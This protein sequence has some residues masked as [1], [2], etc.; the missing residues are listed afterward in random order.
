MLDER[1]I[2]PKAIK[3]YLL[4]NF[5]YTKDVE[6]FLLR[7]RFLKPL[8]LK[9]DSISLP[10]VLYHD[11]Q[12]NPGEITTWDVAL[13]LHH[14]SFV[15]GY[16]AFAK[17][18]WAKPNETLIYVNWVRHLPEKL[19]EPVA[20][21]DEALQRI[22]F[23][24]KRL[25]AT[26]VAF[27]GRRIHALSGQVFSSSELNH[28]ISV[29]NNSGLP[30][31]AKTYREE[32]LLIESLINYH[33]FGGA[34]SVWKILKRKAKSLDQSKI[35]SVFG[36]MNLKYPYANAIGYMLESAEVPENFLDRW[37]ALSSRHLTF[38]LFLGDTESR[39]LSE[40][41]NLFVPKRFHIKPKHG[42]TPK[43]RS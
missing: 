37:M 4:T 40:K 23:S 39:I 41:W 1:L 8:V 11:T 33:Y 17:L 2:T 30:K 20:I 13:S 36:E 12:R 16:S 3:S 27:R 6:T 21:D 15:A 31:Y 22:A 32:R 25:A 9:H 28:L 24:P 42:S 19:A 38:H 35:L 43:R 34:D 7:N 14:Y 18:G 29:P 5:G 26:I 10:H